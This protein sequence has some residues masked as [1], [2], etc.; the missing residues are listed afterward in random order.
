MLQP[1]P[2]LSRGAA[3]VLVV[4]NHSATP[5]AMGALPL[6]QAQA[7]K[8]VLQLLIEGRS[9]QG[10]CLEAQPVV[11]QWA[12]QVTVGGQPHPLEHLHG[13]RGRGK[14]ISVRG[15]SFS[16]QVAALASRGKST[17]TCTWLAGCPPFYLQVWGN[18]TSATHPVCLPAEACASDADSRGAARWRATPPWAGCPPGVPASLWCRW[19]PAAT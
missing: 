15:D 13:T 12:Q 19:A 7:E 6:E 5:Q 8:V 3:Q 14:H 17:C 18:T 1:L 4:M 9:G 11:C 10:L 16:A 2:C